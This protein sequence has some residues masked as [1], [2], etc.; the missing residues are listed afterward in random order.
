MRCPEPSDHGYVR[1]MKCPESVDDYNAIVCFKKSA[2][3]TT[4]NMS[5]NAVYCKKRNEK[6]HDAFYKQ[7]TG[8]SAGRMI[9]LNSRPN[10]TEVSETTPNEQ[11]DKRNVSI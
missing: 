10:N 8:N 11:Y 6:H 1:Q 4:Q 3:E 7:E 5:R 9:Y 2:E